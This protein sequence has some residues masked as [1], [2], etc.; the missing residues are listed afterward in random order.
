L[1]KTVDFL[2][3]ASNPNLALNSVREFVAPLSRAGTISTFGNAAQKNGHQV[4]VQGV[5]DHL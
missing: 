5:T 4:R 2:L 3:P 1:G